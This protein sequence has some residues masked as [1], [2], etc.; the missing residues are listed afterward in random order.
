VHSFRF[1]TDADPALARIRDAGQVDITFSGPAQPVRAR[2]SVTL[3][4][5]VTD[6]TT[7][8][9]RTGLADVHVQLVLAPGTQFDWYHAEPEP[10]GW[11][12]LKVRPPREGAY[13]LFFEC[14][15]IGLEAHEAQRHVI[16]IERPETH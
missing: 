7:A 14:A 16:H 5:R 4:F 10:D 2:E 8:A 12:S 13:Y 15:S 1:R 9:P 3:R 11:Y 6:R